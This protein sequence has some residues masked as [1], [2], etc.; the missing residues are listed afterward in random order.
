MVKCVEGPV[1]PFLEKVR[2]AS[3][4]RKRNE[5]VERERDLY[6]HIYIYIYKW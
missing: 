1:S 4:E 2:N 6:I 5:E 3:E